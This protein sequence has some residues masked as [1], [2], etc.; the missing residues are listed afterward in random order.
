M[1]EQQNIFHGQFIKKDGKLIACSPT[2]SHYKN[3][4][5]TLQEGQKVDVFM[6]SNVDTGT[7][8]QIAKIH[9][10]IRQLAK[11]LG[12]TFEEMKDEIKRKNGMKINDEYKSFADCSKDE[13][14]LVIESIIQVGD[15]VNINFR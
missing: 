12:Y 4:I 6:E 10:C 1:E 15:L 13:L 5:D 8:A 14:G 7:L 2:E 11:D 9:V 3:F